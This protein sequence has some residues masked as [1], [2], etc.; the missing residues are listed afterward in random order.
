[1]LWTDKLIAKLTNAAV[2]GISGSKLDDP[3]L[4]SGIQINEYDLLCFDRNWHGD[5]VVFSVRN[6]LK[7]MLS[8]KS[9]F[10]KD[11]KHFLN[12]YYKTLN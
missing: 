9:Y 2:T 8:V 6:G 12:Y 4:T 3:M 11:R 1:M 10:L 7:D 5:W